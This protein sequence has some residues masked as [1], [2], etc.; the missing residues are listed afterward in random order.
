MVTATLQN[1]IKQGQK[2]IEN[3]ILH[4]LSS[5]VNKARQSNKMTL[6]HGY[7]QKIIA[8]TQAIIP[9]INYNKVINYNRAQTKQDMT[10]ALKTQTNRYVFAN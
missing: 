1:T 2:A 5:M 3:K 4:D 7:A 9:G 8:E 6:P 10:K